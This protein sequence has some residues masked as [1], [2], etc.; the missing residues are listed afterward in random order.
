MGSS[1]IEKINESFLRA[2]SWVDVIALNL[3]EYGMRLLKG[4]IELNVVEN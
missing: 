1:H 3:L 4:F 2:G